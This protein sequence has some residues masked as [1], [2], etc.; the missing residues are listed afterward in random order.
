MATTFTPEQIAAFTTEEIFGHIATKA[1]LFSD[2]SP[3][4]QKAITTHMTGSETGTLRVQRPGEITIGKVKVYATPIVTEVD[5][6]TKVSK[7]TG[8]GIHF[9]GVPGANMKYGTT[10]Y[11]S[12]FEWLID[13]QDAILTW[14]NSQPE[15]TFSVKVKPVATTAATTATAAK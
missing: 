10:L 2:L 8:G 9:Q 15:G 11:K 7:T 4:Q 12:T 14:M 1:L 13:N 3:A 6:K 5:P